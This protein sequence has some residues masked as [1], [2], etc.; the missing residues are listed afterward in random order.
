[1][2]AAQEY[3][4]CRVCRLR[5]FVKWAQSGPLLLRRA[6]RA[7]PRHFMVL[8]LRSDYFFAERDSR[9]C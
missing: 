3:T 1:M 5:N 6:F 2:R 8:A 9:W 7:Q 4:H